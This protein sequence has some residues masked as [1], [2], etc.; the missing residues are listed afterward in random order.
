MMFGNSII[1][2][3]SLVE[4]FRRIIETERFAQA[5]LL[6]GPAGVGQFHFALEFARAVNCRE[7]QGEADC[8]CLSCQKL[9]RYNHPDIRIFMPLPFEIMRLFDKKDNEVF[10]QQVNNLILQRIE[11]PYE[12]LEYPKMSS[13]SIE[14]VRWIKREAQVSP[15][16]GKKKIIILDRIE[17]MSLPAANAF[18]KILEEP[19]NDVFFI[20]I[21]SQLS[22]LIPTIISRCQIY[23]FRRL[24]LEAERQIAAK[25]IK[26]T[27][28][29]FLLSLS[30][31]SIERLLKLLSDEDLPQLRSTVL[32]GIGHFVEGDPGG[33]VEWGEK[34]Q[35]F[36]SQHRTIN[37]W[38][39][40]CSILLFFYYDIFSALTLLD[41]EHFQNQD[42]KEEL[43]LFSKK[44]E[45]SVVIEAMIQIQ[46][47]QQALQQNIQPGIAFYFLLSKLS[48]I[49]LRRM[50]DA[51]V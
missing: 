34:M 32:Q 29:P 47:V 40:F 22:S 15:V 10:Y 39:S 44:T 18:L 21:T 37:P 9:L 19:L 5:Y 31:G 17:E 12:S 24:D 25:L 4:Q 36:F 26:K 35:S 30:R 33:I 41:N 3:L 11:K 49:H 16:E 28:S 50:N 13:L 27:C 42:F 51:T 14:I 7:S 20:L 23:Q 8:R 6:C 46:R 48:M 43:T 1:G 45:L 2:H 38:Q